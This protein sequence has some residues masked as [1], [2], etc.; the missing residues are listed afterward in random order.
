[1]RDPGNEVANDFF[2]L[3]PIFTRPECRK[4]S[5]FAEK[6]LRR[7]RSYRNA[8][9]AGYPCY[10]NLWQLVRLV[11]VLTSLN[12]RAG[13]SKVV[14][15]PK[16]LP[17]VI[18]T[19]TRGTFR[20]VVLR[21]SLALS[22]AA[23]IFVLPP[24]NIMLF[25]C[26]WIPER[27]LT[28][29]SLKFNTRLDAINLSNEKTTKRAP[30]VL[31]MRKEFTKSLRNAVVLSSWTWGMLPETSTAIMTS[32]FLE[33]TIKKTKTDLNE[34]LKPFHSQVCQVQNQV[35]ESQIS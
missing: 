2:A 12:S 33:H 28:L 24:V 30:W 15:P 17:S 6:A 19:T 4:S 27:E 13:C 9:Y 5:L 16:V 35:K 3:A 26:C 34:L 22:I 7:L 14:G 29:A 8:C 1:M 25:I 32:R 18:N 21:S 20:V 11:I 23:V 10:D 31:E